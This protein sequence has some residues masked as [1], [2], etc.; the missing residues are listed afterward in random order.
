M[1]Q[2]RCKKET[3]RCLSPLACDGFGYCRERNSDGRPMDEAT[4]ALRRAE[5][6]AEGINGRDAIDITAELLRRFS[7]GLVRPLW[8]DMTVE[9]KDRWRHEARKFIRLADENGVNIK[10]KHAVEPPS[11]HKWGGA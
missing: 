7:H 8:A 11:S 2:F 6:D 1:R 4:I 10:T 9:Q 5:S 3:G